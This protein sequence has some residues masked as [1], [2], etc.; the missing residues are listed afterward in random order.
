M[1]RGRSSA[2]GDAE[3]QK[4][5]LRKMGDISQCDGCSV[6]F[7][8]HNMDMITSLCKRGILLDHGKIRF[9]GHPTEAVQATRI[10]NDRRHSLYIITGKSKRKAKLLP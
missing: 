8:S 1:G 9:D 7:V 6:P 10:L 4:K 5:S 2:V 3:L